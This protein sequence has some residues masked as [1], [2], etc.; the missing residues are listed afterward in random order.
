[1]LLKLV[2]FMVG[3]DVLEEENLLI[4]C[5]LSGRVAVFQYFLC[6]FLIQV[7]FTKVLLVFYVLGLLFL[8]LI[9]DSL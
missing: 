6:E 2:T 8:M 7:N 3:V 9:V 1:M 4:L 5:F